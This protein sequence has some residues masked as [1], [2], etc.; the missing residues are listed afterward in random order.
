MWSQGSH[1]VACGGL[2][3][4]IAGSTHPRS[5]SR[6]ETVTRG[7]APRPASHGH[8]YGQSRAPGPPRVGGRCECVS[9][10]VFSQNA[11]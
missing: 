6:V 11:S 9:F 2:C 8:G 5:R 3:V 10:F 1:G 7:D 4:L